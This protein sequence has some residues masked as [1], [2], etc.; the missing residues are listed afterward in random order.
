MFQ[1]STP[2]LPKEIPLQEE[3][4]TRK[5]IHKKKQLQDKTATRK[6]IYKTATR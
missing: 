2:R 4:A 5:N 1:P 6:D 3:R